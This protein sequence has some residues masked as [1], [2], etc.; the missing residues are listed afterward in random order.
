MTFALCP[1]AGDCR[2]VLRKQRLGD[3]EVQVSLP[4]VQ[5]CRE[6]TPVLIDD[7]IST[8]RTM[9][10]A[11][12]QLRAASM[13]QSPALFSGDA[14]SDLLDTGVKDNVTCNTIVHPT[15]GIDVFAGIAN[16]VRSMIAE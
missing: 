2:S 12:G 6:C 16:A 10:A 7:I 15:N 11:I 1:L 4:D 5:P 14:Y 8:T 3:H 13:H 9:L